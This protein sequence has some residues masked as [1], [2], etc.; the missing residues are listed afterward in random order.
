[1]KR[2]LAL[3]VCPFALLHP[4]WSPRSSK[5]HLLRPERRH[6]IDI[7]RTPPRNKSP[8]HTRNHHHHHPPCHQTQRIIRS[9]SVQLTRHITRSQNRNRNTDR[10]PQS[11]LKESAP[12]HHPHH[13]PAVRTQRHAQPDLAR[14]PRHLVR[15]NPIQ[16]HRRQHQCQQPEQRRQPR[17]Q[18]LLRKVARHLVVQ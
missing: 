5:R 11:R 9:P 2:T 8:N 18:P 14:P 3:G 4:G 13:V 10:Q 12:H 15:R 1:M 6:R 17:H 16:P 7:P